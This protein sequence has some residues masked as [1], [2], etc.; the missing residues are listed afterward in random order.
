MLLLSGNTHT[1]V[2]RHFSLG[3]HHVGDLTLKWKSI[4]WDRIL[5]ENK[6]FSTAKMNRSSRQNYKNQWVITP[7]HINQMQGRYCHSKVMSVHCW[8]A[9][10]WT[11][12]VQSRRY[13]SDRNRIVYEQKQVLECEGISQTH[14]DFLTYRRHEQIFQKSTNYL[15]ILGARRV[16]FSSILKT[17]G[18]QFYD[19]TYKCA[20]LLQQ[21]VNS[22]QHQMHY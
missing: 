9:Q 7:Y 18:P 1:S 17:Q 4:K 8:L 16:T 3:K 21:E 5:G 13:V 10:Q 14:R 22:L 19:W 15:K 6:Q 20:R 2:H 11:F 12:R